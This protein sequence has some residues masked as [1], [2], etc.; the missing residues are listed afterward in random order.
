[1]TR[2]F[3]TVAPSVLCG[4]RRYS[5]PPTIARLL[6]TIAIVIVALIGLAW[7][8]LTIFLPPAKVRELVQ[9]QL[10]RS[11]SREVRFDGA[12]VGIFPPVRLTVQS[13]ALAE[14]GGFARGVAFQAKSIHLDLDVL[15]LIG[16]KV[17][18]KRLLLD[19][20][21]LHLV[22]REDGTTNLDGLAK[23][24]EPGK[25][26]ANPMDL[27]VDEFRVEK[28]QLLVDDLKSGKRTALGVRTRLSFGQSGTRTRTAGSTTL[29][30]Y[31]FGPLTAARMSDL[32]HSLSQLTLGIDHNGVFDSK[33]KRLA[34][35]K[36]DLALGKATL[37]LGHRR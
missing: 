33:L 12:S 25:A 26:P 24:A 19:E 34:L 10:A 20:P 21:R 27:S 4:R 32:N 3:A 15:Q 5:R 22:L 14:P 2:P 31:A 16:G 35:A 18:V 17:V 13:P 11:L 30:D 9:R 28:G 29:S 8:A 7:G 6:L 1:V 36:L 23:P 37:A